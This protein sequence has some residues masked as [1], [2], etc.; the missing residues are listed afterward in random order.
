M[1]AWFPWMT[2]G[3]WA[4]VVALAARA[5]GRQFATF[6]GVILGIHSL[7]AVEMAPAFARLAPV[8]MALHVAVHLT[9]HW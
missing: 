3:L 6:A 1:P 9:L 8:F 5:R 4:C 2:L 7:I